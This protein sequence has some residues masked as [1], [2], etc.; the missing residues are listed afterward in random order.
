MMM[1]MSKAPNTKLGG[2]VFLLLG[3]SALVFARSE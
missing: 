2:R 3:G 1:M